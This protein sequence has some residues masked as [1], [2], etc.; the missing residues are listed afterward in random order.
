MSGQKLKDKVAVVTGGGR[1]IGRAIAVYMASEGAKIVVNDIA[2]TTSEDGSSFQTADSAVRDIVNNGGAAV[3]NYDTVSTVDGGGNIIATAI[4]NFGRVDILVNNAGILR[5]RMIFNM[6]EDDW[7]AVIAVHLK[8]HFSCT[9]NACILMRQQR[10][11]RVINVSSEAGLGQVGSAGYSAA[12]EGIIGFTR[13]VAREMGKYG[14]T[15]NAIR[16][17]AR[18]EE[19]SGSVW[20][21]TANRAR[22][23]GVT[24]TT[25]FDFDID[26]LEPGDIAPFVS[27]LAS[28]E[29]AGINGYDFIVAGGRISIMSQPEPM[30]TIH[31]KGRWTFEE[32]SDIV[33]K[34][35]M[36]G[37][38]NPAPP[39]SKLDK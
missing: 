18:N 33:P 22:A 14:V 35:L 17:W 15:C 29:A 25:G 30:R 32:L 28:D 20:Q 34:I 13:S 26:R 8:G 21:A 5:S 38:G 24:L 39:Q 19:M 36:S 10:S 4:R 6:T 12:K 23:D 31:K 3:A 11:G 27:Y 16:P 37:L 1:G 7:D 9:K 2:K